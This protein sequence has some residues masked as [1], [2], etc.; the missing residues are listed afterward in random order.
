MLNPEEQLAKKAMELDLRWARKD[1]AALQ[2][3]VYRLRN[4]IAAVVAENAGLRR[5]VEVLQRH[6]RERAA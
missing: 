4:E 1:A 5:A 2:V 6:E 3:E